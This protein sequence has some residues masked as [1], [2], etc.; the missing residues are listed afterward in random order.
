MLFL[1]DHKLYA[2]A[3]KGLFHKNKNIIFNWKFSF[4]IKTCEDVAVSQTDK[5][6]SKLAS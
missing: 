4:I 2:S 1:L 6:S 5:H 3:C